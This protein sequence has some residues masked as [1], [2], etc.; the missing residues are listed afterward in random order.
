MSPLLP[1][2]WQTL[3]FFLNVSQAVTDSLQKVHRL[4]FSFSFR[5]Q[6]GKITNKK[7]KSE[8]IL[9]FEVLDV[10]FGGLLLQLES[11]SL[12]LTNKKLHFA[13]K[14]LIF[15]NCKFWS[16]WSSKTC[17]WIRIRIFHKALIR[18]PI[19]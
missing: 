8:E 11:L 13:T 16:F 17:F 2:I 3:F 4:L 18:I 7:E 1:T 14:N 10:L 15:L 12:R 5:I 9:C 6:K 19:Q